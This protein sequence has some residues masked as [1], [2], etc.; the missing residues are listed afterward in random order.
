MIKFPQTSTKLKK[1]NVDYTFQKYVKM[2]I[3][4][5]NE[6]D[7]LKLIDTDKL[8]VEKKQRNKKSYSLTELKNFANRLGISTSHKTKKQ[9]IELIVNKAKDNGLTWNI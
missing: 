2:N 5:Q 1:I 9:I 4:T 3:H 6:L 7:I 8:L